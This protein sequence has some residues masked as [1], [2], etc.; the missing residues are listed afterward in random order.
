MTLREFIE[1]ING[2]EQY[3]VFM[4]NRDC[5]IY[6]S[7]YKV[8]SP[9]YFND[10]LEPRDDFFENNPYCNDVYQH[11]ELDEETKSFLDKYGNCEIFK[12]ECGSFIPYNKVKMR[13][14]SVQLQRT[15]DELRPYSSTLDCIDLFV[16]YK[17]DSY[18]KL[19]DA[20]KWRNIDYKRDLD[21]GYDA[22]GVKL[23]ETNKLIL[24]NLYNVTTA[25]LAS[26]E[27]E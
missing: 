19:Y 24:L 8:H 6:E 21:R 10:T 25:I 22:D 14:G 27:E 15:F 18:S 26:V 9:Y 11:K 20:V 13:D 4:P 17:E 16:C 3:R 23:N 1:K 2:G 7:Y 5:L 12:I